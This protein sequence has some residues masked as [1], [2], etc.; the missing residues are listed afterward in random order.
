MEVML[1][2]TNR[3][4]YTYDPNINFE[5]PDN[6]YDYHLQSTIAEYQTVSANTDSIDN[7]NEERYVL[8]SR[9]SIEIIRCELNDTIR[10]LTVQTIDYALNICSNNYMC[11]TSK[12]LAAL[13]RQY[14]AHHK[15]KSTNSMDDT[16]ADQQQWQAIITSN[17]IKDQTV[18]GVDYI[19]GSMLDVLYNYR[20]RVL[21]Y[22]IHTGAPSKQ[23]SEMSVIMSARIALAKNRVIIIEQNLIDSSTGARLT[24]TRVEALVLSEIKRV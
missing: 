24:N 20:H 5:L 19:S 7:N 13:N 8:D 4:R 23:I 10:E 6:D 17:T 1:L 9:P 12:L 22:K 3:T 14:V 15:R 2:A 21:L 11:A 18:I 16:G